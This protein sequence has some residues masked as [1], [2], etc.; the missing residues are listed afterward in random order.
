MTLERTF[1]RAFSTT[2]TIRFCL[3]RERKLNTTALNI[4]KDR[5]FQYVQN[6]DAKIDSTKGSH[7]NVRD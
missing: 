7:M 2:G 4:Y 3:S 1:D 5:I 6:L